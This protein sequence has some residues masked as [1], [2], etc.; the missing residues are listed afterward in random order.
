MSKMPCRTPTKV[1]NRK[2]V[3]VVSGPPGS[4]KSTYAKRISKDFCLDY[5]TTGSFFREIARSRGLSLAEL[6]EIAARDP[7]I[8][9]EIDR[10]SLKRA[11]L[12][13]VVID[14]HLAGWVLSDIAD[15]RIMVTAPLNERVSRIA[16]REGVDKSS[17]IEETLA[18]EFSQAERFLKY[19]G[20]DTS[21]YQ[22]FDL[23]IDTSDL[24]I[25]E[26]YKIIKDYI[27]LKLKALGYS[28]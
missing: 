21:N 2:P 28:F 9:L 16:S 12:G 10:M 13:G 27:E 18:R 4:G 26:V 15:V 22:G 20:Y 23:V 24:G 7:T 17:I 14:S 25:E 6:S 3:I 19:Y 1:N 8:D 5:I 11:R